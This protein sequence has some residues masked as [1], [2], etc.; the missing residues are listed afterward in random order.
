[1]LPASVQDLKFPLRDLQC[2]MWETDVHKLF[3]TSRGGVAGNLILHIAWSFIS[4]VVA[5]LFLCSRNCSY[6]DKY[7]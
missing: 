7:L 3:R 2:R 1:L 6:T 5:H 4:S